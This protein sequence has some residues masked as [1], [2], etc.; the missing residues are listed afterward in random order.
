V[1]RPSAAQTRGACENSGVKQVDD[2]WKTWGSKQK[3]P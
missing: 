3:S 2:Q 1:T